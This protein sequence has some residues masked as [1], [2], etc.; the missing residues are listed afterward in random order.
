MRRKE[1]NK[2]WKKTKITYQ[3][4]WPEG[5]KEINPKYIKRKLLKREIEEKVGIGVRERIG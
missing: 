3:W 4:N 5:N 2:Q 1:I